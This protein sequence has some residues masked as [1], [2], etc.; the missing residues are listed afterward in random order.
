[1]KSLKFLLVVLMIWLAT[2]I[3]VWSFAEMVLGDSRLAHVLGL[4]ETEPYLKILVYTLFPLPLAVG[5]A[6]RV[7][8]KR[9][10]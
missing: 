6:R 4:E 10:A 9:D 5:L 7:T 3:I 2:Q 8:G 1:M